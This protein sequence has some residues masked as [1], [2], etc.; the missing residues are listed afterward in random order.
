MSGLRALLPALLALSSGACATMSQGE[1]ERATQVATHARSTQ[2]DCAAADHCAQP[3]PLHDLGGKAL[4]ASGPDAPRH[5]ALILDRGPQALLARINLLRSARA[6]IDLQTY[7]FDEDDAGRLVLDELLAAARRGVRVRVLIDQLSALKSVDTLAALTGVHVNFSMRIY[8]PVLNRARISYP[9]YLIAGLC[10]F[11]RLNQRMHNKLLLID[12]EIGITG[13]RNYQDDYY[14]W[15][16]QYNF[17]DRDL[18]VAGPVAREMAANFQAFWDSRRTVPVAQLGDVGRRLLQRG[19]P[20]LKPAQYVQPQRAQA[21]LRDAGDA[22]L[23]ERELAAQAMPVGVVQFIADLPQKHRRDRARAEAAAPATPGLSH[24]IASA[25]HEV[26]LQTPYL[27]LSKPAQQ[28]FEQLQ[29]RQPPPNVIISTNSLAATDS[30]ITYALSHKYKRRYLRDFGFQIYEFKP[31]P[32]T[33]PVDL[34]AT[35]A[36]WPATVAPLTLPGQQAPTSA[37]ATAPASADGAKPRATPLQREFFAGRYFG[38]NANQPVPLKHAGVRIGLHAKSLVIDN[39]IGVVGTHNFDPRSDRYNTESAVVIEDPAFAQALADSIRGDIAPENSWVIAR[40]PKPP[41]FSGLE[42]SLAKISEHLPIF[43]LWPVR[44]ATSYAFK[45]GPQ[46]PLPL[47][48]TDSRFAQCYEP[49]G[50]YPEVDIGLKRLSTRIFT[51]FG[52]GLAPIL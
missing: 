5:Y 42:Y 23:I 2:I 30:F 18:L 38:N 16:P 17:R 35:G 44:Y 47:P 9:Q 36:Q 22:E 6:R 50:D 13:G 34:I 20:A 28:L 31:F 29:Q 43:D 1:R 40:R 11:R 33:A 46:C 15:D 3:S 12:D 51:A 37:T 7:I 52:A 48:P 49:V 32:E 24:L 21:M 4:L 8:N 14:D 25:Q 39:R 19:V 10:C 41:V 26:L 27:V 45:P